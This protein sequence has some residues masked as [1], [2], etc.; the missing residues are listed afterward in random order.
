MARFVMAID[1]PKCM[2]CK[3]CILACQQRNAVPYGNS[4]NWIKESYVGGDQLD[5]WHYQPGGCM[6]CAAP[7]CVKACPTNA[8][9]KGEDGV[10]YVDEG[11][12]I[13]CSACI[14]ACPYQARFKHPV[15]GTADKCDYCLNA[16]G[17]GL[18]PACVHVCPTR[19][20]VFGDADN[21]DSAVAKL[22]FKHHKQNNLTY[23]ESRKT[24]TQP[25]LAYIGNTTPTDW[26]KQAGLPAAV[27]AM[28]PVSTA[29]RWL[30]G[31]SLAGVII[32]FLK[33]LILPSEDKSGDE[34]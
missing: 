20:R 30:G 27:A 22:L 32:V 10:V 34:S 11:R 33:Q 17:N 9:F 14:A 25:T 2:N 4:R 15:Y 16:R 5:G 12:C 23:V 19:A 1:A 29:I 8:T 24:P 18:E 21:P 7:L 13:G 26:P 6:Q 31:L 3:A 28:V